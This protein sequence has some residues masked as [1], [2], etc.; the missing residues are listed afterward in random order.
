MQFSVGVNYWPR[1]SATAMWQQF[2]AGEIAEDFARMAGLG[3]DGVRF[4]V[5]W[6]EFQPE[7]DRL[8]ETMLGRLETLVNVASDAGLR[9]VPVLFCGHSSGANYVPEWALDRKTRSGRFPT[10]IGS[11]V[12][13]SGAADIYGNALREPQ[14]LFARTI[15]ERLRGHSAIRAW[16]IGNAFSRVREPVHAKLSTGEHSSEPAGEREMAAW[17]A[18]LSRTLRESSAL[19][20]TAGASFDDL[21]EDRDVR[22]GTLCAPFAF[23]SI[24][25]LNVENPF[26][27]NRL[28]PEAT[29]FFAMLAAAF[30]FKPVFVTGFGIPAC[31]AGKFSA[32]EHFA[33]P[34]ESPELAISPEDSIFATYPCA[35][36][37]ENAAFGSAVLERLHAD[38]RLGAY[39]WA[40][41]DY[42]EPIRAATPFDDAAHEAAS[43][44]I[45]SDGSEKPVAAALAR[46]ARE[47]RPVVD[48]SDMPMIAAAY[49]YRTLPKSAKTLYDAYLR[50]VSERRAST[51]PSGGAP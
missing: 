31:P 48:A 43:G 27:R 19:P 17:S 20:V 26:A 32:F 42:P 37:E 9:A 8:D 33:R 5:R 38:G 41:A 18:A 24:G 28:D 6:D 34:G 49:Y 51:A 16:D 12:S 25:G 10:I 44:L 1:S 30:S 45:R 50:F 11:S 47:K 2:D 46:F 14:L 15:G 23:T 39:W 36:E 7:P 40:W 13:R 35:S 29:P 22:F 21:A 3:F 4:F